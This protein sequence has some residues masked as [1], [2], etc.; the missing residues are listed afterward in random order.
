MSK[1]ITK[2]ALDCI[3]CQSSR[4]SKK[5]KANLYTPAT[6]EQVSYPV[7]PN[8][9]SNYQPYAP[10][11]NEQVPYPVKPNVSLPY[12]PYAPAPNAQV[13][14]PVQPN[15]SLPYQPYS[16]APNEQ[17][18]Y[19][20][21]QNMSLPY[22]PYATTPGQQPSPANEIY[23]PESNNQSKEKN[24]LAI[25]WI[26][27]LPPSKDE[28][29][30]VLAVNTFSKNEK[31][32]ASAYPMK[33]MSVEETFKILIGS[34][35]DLIFVDRNSQLGMA[36]IKLGYL[37][38]NWHSDSGLLQRHGP[39][40]ECDRREICVP[41]TFQ[42]VSDKFRQN[43]MTTSKFR[44][45]LQKRLRF[46]QENWNN[47]LQTY[48]DEVEYE[49]NQV[50]KIGVDWIENLTPSNGFNTLLVLVKFGH[51]IKF[52][53]QKGQNAS[54]AN[55]FQVAA[56]PM[57]KKCVKT[58]FHILES[59]C[60]KDMR[61]PDFV[62]RHFIFVGVG[63]D[64]YKAMK[65]ECKSKVVLKC[66]EKKVPIEYW[67]KPKHNQKGEIFKKLKMLDKFR[68]GLKQRMSGKLNWYSSLQTDIDIEETKLEIGD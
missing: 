31:R 41:V 62:G 46:G 43:L 58:A 66:N 35:S 50:S 26:G 28:H 6:N 20:V 8:T 57:K 27:P 22:Q 65:K 14:Y 67:N 5:N 47:L 37:D 9:S 19:P 18:S 48:V 39:K 36:M 1:D 45:E 16:P 56:Y 63:S 7:Q 49:I 59:Y 32:Q 12:Q 34:N 2:M 33:R 64:F 61:R 25:D 52:N 51:N 13:S 4:I 23:S 24:K 53:G 38:V 68:N 44:N 15:T 30:A 42:K 11:P 29:T 40:N 21:Q 17:V 55:E 3:Q 54:S 60:Q 10:A